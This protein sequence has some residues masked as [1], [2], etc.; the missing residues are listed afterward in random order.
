ME[1]RKY[2]IRWILNAVRLGKRGKRS[3]NLGFCEKT[4]KVAFISILGIKNTREFVKPLIVKDVYAKREC[5][6]GEYCWNLECPH[7]RTTPE[8]LKR[9][10]GEKCDFRAFKLVSDRLQEIGQHL[11]SEIDWGSDGAIAYTEAPLILSLKRK[12]ATK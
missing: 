12:R 2:K 9:Y 4:K 1:A 3:I 8:T 11:V 7:N 5:E 10:L 6:D